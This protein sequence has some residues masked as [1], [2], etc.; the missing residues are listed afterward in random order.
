M[1]N[2]ETVFALIRE[3]RKKQFAK[4]GKQEH[5][6]FVWLTIL[7]EEVGEVAEAILHDKF[8]GSHA[9]TTLTELI[10]VAAVAVQWLESMVK[11]S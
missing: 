9:G 11:K 4:W 7:I 8:G 1:E 6:D 5:D 3:E 10:H 2:M